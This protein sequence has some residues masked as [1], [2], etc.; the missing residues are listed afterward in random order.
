MHT[1]MGLQGPVLLLVAVGSAAAPGQ[2]GTRRGGSAD[3]AAL[4]ASPPLIQVVLHP[5]RSGSER[6]P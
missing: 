2:R 4:I 1:S 5:R 6:V 3:G